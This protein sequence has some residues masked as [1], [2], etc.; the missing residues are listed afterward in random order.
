MKKDTRS[1]SLL[2]ITVKI[3]GHVAINFVKNIFQDGHTALMVA[4]NSNA[5]NTIKILLDQNAQI[6]YVN[7]VRM[8]YDN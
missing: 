4:A 8:D 3:A 2:L 1:K 6:D 5:F 7:K